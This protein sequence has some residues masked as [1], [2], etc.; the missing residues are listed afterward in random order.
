MRQTGAFRKLG[1]KR[2]AHSRKSLKKYMCVY[3]TR[4]NMSVFYSKH[5][6]D[7]SAIKRGVKNGRF[8]RGGVNQG[9]FSGGRDV[10]W[11]NAEEPNP[12]MGVGCGFGQIGQVTVS[13]GKRIAPTVAV[14]VT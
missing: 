5:F 9:S 10:A 3:Y 14:L 13:V 2:D 7:L 1:M 8:G 11:R 4:Y 6:R 12:C